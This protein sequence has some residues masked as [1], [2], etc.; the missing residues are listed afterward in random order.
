MK[1]MDFGSG[2][3]DSKTVWQ[4]IVCVVYKVSRS[5]VY[6]NKRIKNRQNNKEERENGSI[7]F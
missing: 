3:L 7:V 6:D 4:N 1:R 5:K 2:N